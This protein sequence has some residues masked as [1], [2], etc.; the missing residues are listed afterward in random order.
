MFVKLPR[1]LMAAVNNKALHENANVFHNLRIQHKICLQLN[2][3][4][5]QQA[6]KSLIQQKRFPD[7]TPM[8]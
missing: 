2:T 4:V 3:T 5:V 1:S 7:E 6:N 8:I